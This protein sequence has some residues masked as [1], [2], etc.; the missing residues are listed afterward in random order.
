[1][2]K[3]ICVLIVSVLASSFGTAFAG[4]IQKAIAAKKGFRTY[5]GEPIYCRITKAD[6]ERARDL[7]NEKKQAVVT[8]L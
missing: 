8:I 3:A 5:I 7:A 4:N 6:V 2:K 1:M